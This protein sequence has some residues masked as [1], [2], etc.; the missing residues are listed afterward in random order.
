MRTN[1]LPRSMGVFSD[2]VSRN[3]N[4]RGHGFGLNVGVIFDPSRTNSPI[5]RGA[6]YWGGAAGTWFW[7]D[8]EHDV[9]FIGMI[10]R[11]GGVRGVSFRGESIGLVY[12][13]LETK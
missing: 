13:A 2:G 6:Y 1:A 11:F 3:P 7:I 4:L 5:G 12:D 9:I 8:P 10:Q